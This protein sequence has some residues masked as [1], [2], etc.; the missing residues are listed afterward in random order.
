MPFVSDIKGPQQPVQTPATL[1]TGSVR[2]TSTIDTHQAG[3]GDSDVD[4]RARDAVATRDGVDLS[5]I[6]I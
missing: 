4:M 3:P 5:L 6:H 2:R 1:T